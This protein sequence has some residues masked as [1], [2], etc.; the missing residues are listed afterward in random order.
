[1]KNSCITIFVI[2]VCAA[3]G[4]GS[5]QSDENSDPYV[6][7]LLSMYPQEIDYTFKKLSTDS[8]DITMPL[9]LVGLSKNRIG[10]VDGFNWRISIV[11]TSNQVLSS[12]QTVGNGPDE[13]VQVNF[14][15]S[16]ND[17]IAVIDARQNRV[18]FLS[19]IEDTLE[20]LSTAHFSV[21]QE[22]TPIAYFKDDNQHFLFFRKI[23]GPGQFKSDYALVWTKSFSD[24]YTHIRTFRDSDAITDM[25]SLM[26]RLSQLL[27]GFDHR[28]SSLAVAHSDSLVVNIKY[29]E[30]E[31]W[32]RI[33]LS[34]SEKRENTDFNLDYLNY[35]SS[36]EE[37]KNFI[38]RSDFL[39]II[40]SMEYKNGILYLQ[41]HYYGGPDNIIMVH[42]LINDTTKFINA[43]LGYHMLSVYDSN[44]YGIHTDMETGE[45]NIAILSL[46]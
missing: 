22:G 8:L 35:A 19:A 44:I 6:K 23:P 2:L 43:P 28:N 41:L 4:S 16:I 1:M 34:N 27:I 21:R 26:F 29:P 33:R 38:S 39:P 5:N 42:S 10:V 11:D 30:E 37:F 40:R 3:C 15:S 14:L 13:W 9:R 24:T 18:V 36:T 46:N 25:T 45:K 12:L 17:T 32:K 7:Y 20:P 31:N